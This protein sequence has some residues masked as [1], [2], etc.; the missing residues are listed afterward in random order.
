MLGTVI[1]RACTDEDLPGCVR[2]LR[3][4]HER[5][6][7]PAWWPDDPAAWLCPSGYGAGWVAHDEAGEILG[8]VCVVLNPEALSVALDDGGRL[9]GVSRLFV[10]PAARGRGLRLGERLL[11][12]AQDWAFGHGSQLVLEVVDDGG[13]AVA[14]YERL[15]W[16]L[17]D[18]RVADWVTPSGHRHHLR[19]Y[20]GSEAGGIH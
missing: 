13:P 4:V 1:V 18:R 8:H 14:L 3:A 10:A 16:R 11:A 15:G 17:V 2:A 12:A 20:L 19:I 9:V 6:G 5:D 7:Y